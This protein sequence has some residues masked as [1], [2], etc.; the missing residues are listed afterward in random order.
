MKNKGEEEKSNQEKKKEQ[1]KEEHRF[2]K[3]CSV[4]KGESA[5]F[6]P[7]DEDLWGSQG[8]ATRLITLRTG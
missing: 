6:I 1:S 7:Y 8:I 2:T 3:T 4:F 5:K